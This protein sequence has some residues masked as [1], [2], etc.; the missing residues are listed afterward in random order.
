MGD[1]P[2]PETLVKHEVPETLG[3]WQ[4]DEYALPESA[5]TF[6]TRCCE[7]AEASRRAVW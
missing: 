5:G 7:M 1:D 2:G 6:E 3:W 4:M